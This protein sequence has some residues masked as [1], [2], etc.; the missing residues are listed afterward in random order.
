MPVARGGGGGGTLL[1]GLYTCR[2]NRL[3]DHSPASFEYVLDSSPVASVA[4]FQPDKI[5]YNKNNSVLS[6]NT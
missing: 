4:H 2:L 3:C 6:L 1:Y 5:Y